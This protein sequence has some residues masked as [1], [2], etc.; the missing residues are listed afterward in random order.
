MRTSP[1]TIFVIFFLI[2]CSCKQHADGII[3]DKET[4]RPVDRVIVTTFDTSGNTFTTYPIHY[5][6]IDGHFKFNKT[7]G[8]I[9]Q[10]PDLI[11]YFKRMGYKTK[12]MTFSPSTFNDTVYLEK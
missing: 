11:I 10:C 5:S 12:R 6:Q 4:G 3:L 2:G 9:G 8:K 7:S 1:I